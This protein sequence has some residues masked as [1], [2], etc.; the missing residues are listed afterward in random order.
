MLGR[1][2]DAGSTREV[3]SVGHS[4]DVWQNSEFIARCMWM[5]KFHFEN[6]CT[7]NKNYN[8]L[9]MWRYI[10]ILYKHSTLL[11]AYIYYGKWLSEEV[12]FSICRGNEA[13]PKPGIGKFQILHH[14]CQIWIICIH[15]CT[16]IEQDHKHLIYA[17][18]SMQSSVQ[19]KYVLPAT[20]QKDRK[21]IR[22]SAQL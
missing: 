13:T 19:E 22:K 10:Y 15:Q 7:A 14:L 20:N 6:Y 11:Y 9:C 17:H 4:T 12:P 2:N 8:G 16:C 3:C 1:E 21:L 18:L 5:M